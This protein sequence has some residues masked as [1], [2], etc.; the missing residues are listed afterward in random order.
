MKQCSLSALL[1]AYN[2]DHAFIKFSSNV[3]TVHAWLPVW[4]LCVV[5]VFVKIQCFLLYADLILTGDTLSIVGTFCNSSSKETRPKFSLQ[6]KIV[7]RAYSSTKWS[8]QSLCK[9]AGD[10]LKSEET[11]SCQMKIP[12][13]VFPTIRN[14]EI[15]SVEYYLKVCNINIDATGL[16]YINTDINWLTLLTNIGNYYFCGTDSDC[17]K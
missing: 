12:V 4:K 16:M 14:C 17:F 10:K 3:H 1:N 8:E 15:I 5:T 2:F 6:Q 9:M 13:D 11:I 7:Y